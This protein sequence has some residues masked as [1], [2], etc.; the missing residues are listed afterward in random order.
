M[1]LN[2]AAATTRPSRSITRPAS[3]LHV[4]SLPSEH[5]IGDLGPSAFS[6]VDR[7]H[8][9]GQ[10]WWQALPLRPTGYGHSPYEAMASFAGNAMVISPVL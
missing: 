5:G 9:S 10:T 3:C 7:L 4:T 1:S 2:G 6:W 8:D